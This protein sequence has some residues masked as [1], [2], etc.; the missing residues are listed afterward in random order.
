MIKMITFIIC[1]VYFYKV[2]KEKDFKKS[3][4]GWKYKTEIRNLVISS[5]D[6][7]WIGIYY[8]PGILH[9]HIG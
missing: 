9:T 5:R 2:K 1:Y 3:I 7:Y 8:I 6:M 4:A